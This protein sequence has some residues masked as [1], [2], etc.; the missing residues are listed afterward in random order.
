MTVLKGPVLPP[1]LEEVEDLPSLLREARKEDL[2]I[3][4]K[5][6]RNITISD[7]DASGLCFRG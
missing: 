2:D 3:T 5:R 1:E 6:L 7:A 4:G